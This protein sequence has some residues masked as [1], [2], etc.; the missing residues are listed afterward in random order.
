[1]KK[2]SNKRLWLKISAA[3]IVLATLTGIV[4][5]SFFFESYTR[6]KITSLLKTRFGHRYK[7]TFEKIETNV[8]TRTIEFKLKNI[9]IKTDTTAKDRGYLPILNV[10]AEEIKIYNLSIRDILFDKSLVLDSCSFNNSEISITPINISESKNKKKK[11]KK[12]QGISLKKLKILDSKLEINSKESNHV[13]FSYENTDLIIVNPKLKF[14]TGK[15]PKHSFD[16]IKL[17]TDK[18]KF[19]FPDFDYALEADTTV[20]DYNNKIVKLSNFILKPKFNINKEAEDQKYQKTYTEIFLGN[21]IIFNLNYEDLEKGEIHSDSV[22]LEKL[23]LN[24]LKNISKPKKQMHKPNLLELIEAIQLKINIPF[25]RFYNSYFSFEAQKYGYNE[26]TSITIDQLSGYIKNFHSGA[27]KNDS[28]S[29]Y[30][31]GKLLDECII[32]FYNKMYKRDSS[33]LEIYNGYIGK[34]DLVHINKLVGKLTPLNFKSGVMKSLVFQGESFNES[35]NG[36]LTMCYNDLKIELHSKEHKTQRLKTSLA[37]LIIR[38]NNPKTKNSKAVEVNYE[39]E[40]EYNQAHT[41]LW[42]GGLLDGI[43]STVIKG[44]KNH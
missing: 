30:L 12:L 9:E 20:I 25:I 33:Y 31:K 6:N 8:T 44:K 29:F 16:D 21:T 34:M 38:H 5:Y 10:K 11:K 23:E 32:E 24:L 41:A 1:M 37:N 17:T 7:L 35:T 4:F 39:F 3:I 43:K 22:Y 27:Y 26:N 18:A 19:D 2:K 40:K 42:L 15:L 28:L 36:K 14:I 13:L